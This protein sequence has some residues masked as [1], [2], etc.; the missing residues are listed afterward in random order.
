MILTLFDFEKKWF[1]LKFEIENNL[2]FNS[3]LVQIWDKILWNTTLYFRENH[4]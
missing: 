4:L 2:E 1:L 3:N